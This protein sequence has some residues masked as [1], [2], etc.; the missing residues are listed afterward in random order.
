MAK[1]TVTRPQMLWCSRVVVLITE[2]KV[3][4]CKGWTIE[5]NARRWCARHAVKFVNLH[6]KRNEPSALG[7]L[8]ALVEDKS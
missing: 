8:A 7:L 6:A 3:R 5:E 4:T 2:G 1:T